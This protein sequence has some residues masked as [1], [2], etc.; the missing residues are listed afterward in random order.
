[1][2]CADSST[3]TAAAWTP[4]LQERA[5]Q[6][7]PIFERSGVAD[8][9]EFC[10]RY[11]LGWPQVCATVGSTS[12]AGNLDA[13]LRAVTPP[14]LA[15]LPDDI[16]AELAALQRTWSDAVDIHAEPWTM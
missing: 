14:E 11:A 16:Q 6:V 8:W 4:Y 3:K 9:T 7:A 2:C 15:P 12:H 5:V 1:M 10:V 13:Y